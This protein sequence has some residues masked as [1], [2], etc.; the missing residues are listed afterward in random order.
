VRY[1]GVLSG[2]TAPGGGTT[3]YAIHIFH[4]ALAT[5]K[6][7]CFLKADTRLPM[8]YYPDCL[9][10]TV[11]FLETPRAQLTQTTYN[12]GAMDFTPA[13]LADEL[14]KHVPLTVTYAPDFRQAI[15]DSWPRSLDDSL[16]RRDWGWAPTY[17]VPSMVRAMLQVIRATFPK[18]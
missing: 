9:A 18:H 17:D 3:D 11:K 14:R 16:A 13:E 8:M 12:M 2:D 5:G 4:E 7:T 15:A 6:Y 10:G 1:P